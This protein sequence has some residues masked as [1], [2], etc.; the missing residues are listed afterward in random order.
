MFTVVPIKDTTMQTPQ[1]KWYDE[2]A[3][4]FMLLIVAILSRPYIAVPLFLVLLILAL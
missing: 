3:T 2:L 1:I 4:F